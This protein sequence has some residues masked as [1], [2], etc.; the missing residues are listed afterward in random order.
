MIRP[1]PTNAPVRV[2]R[3][4][5]LVGAGA[6]VIAFQLG[7]DG[8]AATKTGSAGQAL[9]A[10]VRIGSDDSV[11]LMLS[12]CEIGQGISTTLPAILADELGADW[13][14]VRVENAPVAPA[15][16]SPEAK[17]MF[18]GNSASTQS[19]APV[20][21]QAGAAAR[22][23]LTKAAATRFGVAPDECHS[24]DGRI[25]HA[26]S[27]RSLTFG[28]VAQAA[29]SLPVP[30]FPSLRP[31]TE[32]QL[33][34]HAVARRDIPGK[35]DGSAIFGIDV[36]VPGMV[37]AAIRQA[38]RFGD[39][40]VELNEA[41][42]LKRPGVLAVVPL[43]NGAAV[44][45]TH[46]W[47]AKVAADALDIRFAA[48]R[49]AKPGSAG[50]GSAD[51]ARQYADAMAG[52]AWAKAADV[53]D[54]GSIV[55]AAGTTF[56]QDYASPFQAHATMEPMNCTALVTADRCEIW[57]STQGPELTLLVATK[58]T[59]LPKE[60]IAVH[61]TLAGGG[62]GRRLVADFVEQAILI[63]KA[64]RRPVKLIW[65]REE[66]MTHDIYR[67][68]TLARLS[69]ALDG[70]GRPRAIHAKLVSATQL[71]FVGAQSIKNG[72][73]PRC[74]E[75]LDETIYDIADFRL[76]F[77][78][79]KL[80]VPTSVL[81]TTGFGPN[82]FAIESFIDEL[83]HRAGK[84]PYQ[85]RRQLL[86]KNKRARKVLDLAA[87][88][89]GWNDAIASHHG[90]GIAVVKA[91]DA[92][93]AQAVELSVDAQKAVRIHRVVTAADPGMVFD[94]G[95]AAS[96][97]EGGVIWGL[98]SAFKSEI[99]F[100]DG[101]CVERNFDGYDVAHLWESPRAVDTL[102]VDGDPRGKIGGLGEGG[103][104]PLP[105]AV[106]NAIFAA[107]GDRIRTLPLSRGGYS[108]AI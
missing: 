80:A 9:N 52:S 59:G 97:L 17:W 99:T 78:M 6:L 77:A 48:P 10:W 57:V 18:T 14:R 105:P 22:E 88:R 27:G 63:S 60:K 34:G 38:P 30:A 98:T 43:A 20:M 95:I 46:F 82:A 69:A 23:M 36:Q 76:D 26:A 42:V 51:L 66:D 103:P 12:Q 87:E 54:A 64:V 21:R 93:L 94:P 11:T 86:E 58:T 106:A 90:R 32:L 100:A 96:N 35:T 41:A 92:Y 55:A 31:D 70:N 5:V 102:L 108:M 2:D 79:P 107:T 8:R 81:R 71:Q 84:D 33:V 56:T 104:V 65:T 72:I 50:V 73:D 61:R 68:A 4:S 62:F 25:V 47:Q 7:D 89:I 44:V 53:G 3:R 83:A 15:Y 28:A 39:V 101:G 1:P 37:Y 19:F 91:F 49:S 67:P 74:T 85:Y 13:S 24:R 75:G 16:Q 40:V 29:A 45:A